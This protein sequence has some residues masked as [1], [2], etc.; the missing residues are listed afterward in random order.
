MAID[1][2][3]LARDSEENLEKIIAVRNYN[4]L[5]L[6][7]YMVTPFTREEMMERAISVLSEIFQ[8]IHQ[9]GVRLKLMEP[10]HGPGHIARD[11]MNALALFSRL[12]GNPREI[13]I[14]ILAGTLHDIGC[15]LVDRYAEKN[16]LVRHAEVGALLLESVFAEADVNLTEEER[17]L[18]CYAVAAH[19]HYLKP[20]Q[21]ASCQESAVHTLEPYRD[22]TDDGKPIYAVWYPRWVDRLDCVGPGF[23]ARHYL[24]L[25]K[26]HQDYTSK[27]FVDVDFEKHMQPLF[28]EDAGGAHTMLGHLRMFAQSQVNSSPYGK[29][30]YGR[31][32]ELR[33]R[34]KEWTDEVYLRVSQYRQID[35]YSVAREVDLLW[36]EFLADKIE[37]TGKG[38][39]VADQLQIMFKQLPAETQSAWRIGFA[40]VMQNYFE[41]KLIVLADAPAS[42]LKLPGFSKTIREML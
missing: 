40:I 15:A 36:H 30:D 25:A 21:I 4:V 9:A 16:R 19:T 29:H 6:V 8:A 18:V 34:A 17:K 24:T 41:W 38:A 39:A 32:I 12:E 37:P 14:G 22:S 13:F 7:E 11:H 2:I 31:M 28:D 23:I 42:E 3:G 10:G 20:I 26:P 35:G 1:L 27:G 5:Q 33:D